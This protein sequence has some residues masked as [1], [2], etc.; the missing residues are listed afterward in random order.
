M[1]ADFL[2]ATV[3]DGVV[4]LR[5]LRADDA[6]V[7]DTGCDSEARRFLG[8]G[9]PGPS[10]TAVVLDATDR[11]VGW[12]DH[13]VD[14]SWLGPAEMNIGNGTMPDAR[15]RGI[16]SRAVALLLDGLAE[17]GELTIATVLID[18]ENTPPLSVARRAGFEF[19]REFD[20]QLL[21]KRTLR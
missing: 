20:D 3:T 5:R 4:T 14:R 17:Q 12:V 2:D 1:H 7:L 11:I 18:R 8:E 9:P 10:P 19:D 15:G 6:D 13:D 21:L 16:A